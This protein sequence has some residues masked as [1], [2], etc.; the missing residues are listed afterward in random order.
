MKINLIM[1]SSKKKHEMEWASTIYTRVGV[2]KFKY[3]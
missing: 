1:E 3:T 2:L